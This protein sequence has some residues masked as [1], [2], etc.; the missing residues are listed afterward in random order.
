MGHTA[1]LFRS[2][3]QPQAGSLQAE[4][5]GP[6]DRWLCVDIQPIF[7]RGVIEFQPTTMKRDALREI[8]N[9]PVNPISQNGIAHRS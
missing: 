1:G 7:G 4:M 8:V 9:R 2:A 6:V 5:G 3:K